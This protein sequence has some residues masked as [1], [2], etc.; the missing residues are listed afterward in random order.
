M[1]QNLAS[2]S[3]KYS[4]LF[5]L[6]NFPRSP[7]RRGAD[8]CVSECH[9]GI[10]ESAFEPALPAILP[11]FFGSH[12][13]GESNISWTFDETRHV[14]GEST[15]QD[16]PSMPESF[17]CYRVSRNRQLRRRRI[18]R[19]RRQQS[20]YLLGWQKLPNDDINVNEK[21]IS[22]TTRVQCVLYTERKEWLQLS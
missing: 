6:I 7:R 17:T 22:Q 16:V 5:F 4:Y 14:A 19:D 21:F 1:Q 3:N 13:S 2:R 20:G 18:S 8:L 12:K 10:G 15:C 11:R 9:L